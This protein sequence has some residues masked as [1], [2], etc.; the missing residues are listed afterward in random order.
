MVHGPRST[1][2]VRRSL[3]YGHGVP[4]KSWPAEVFAAS[5]PRVR[6]GWE[7]GVRGIA[8]MA[9]IAGDGAPRPPARGWERT[10]KTRG[11]RSKCPPAKASNAHGQGHAHPPGL[12]RG[13]S[14]REWIWDTVK[15]WNK[16]IPFRLQIR[17][18]RKVIRLPLRNEL[19]SKR[20]IMFRTA[21]GG[22][23]VVRFG[24]IGREKRSQSEPNCQ[25]VNAHWFKP[26]LSH[27]KPLRLLTQFVIRS[28]SEGLIAIESG[29]GGRS[30]LPP[31]GL[32][33]GMYHG[34]WTMAI[35]CGQVLAG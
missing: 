30:L 21:V 7:T 31:H 13:L 29:E 17:S 34:Q 32:P 20:A 3:D 28:H 35:E 18:S 11:E 33:I 15:A 2:H 14:G 4:V 6:G 26:G 27:Q 16:P 24:W 22:A 9:C 5:W 23:Y 12:F 19:L 25:L 8:V 1:V 10:W